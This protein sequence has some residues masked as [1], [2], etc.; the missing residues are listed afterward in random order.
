MVIGA[1]ATTSPYS[2]DKVGS[3]WGRY[4]LKMERNGIEEKNISLQ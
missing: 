3:M 1:L 2:V 4:T